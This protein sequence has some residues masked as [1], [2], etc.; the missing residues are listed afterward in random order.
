MLLRPMEL[1]D[2]GSL[3]SLQRAT[4]KD[5]R[6]SYPTYLDL[7]DRNHS[8]DGLATHL[9]V[10]AALDT[11]D[12]SSR[13]WV[14]SASGNY[15]DVLR[16]KPHLGRF[17]HAEDEHGPNSAPYVVLSY[18]YWRSHFNDD[19]RVIGR[20]VRIN[21]HPFTIIGVAPAEFH[22]TVLFFFPDLYTP[23]VNHAQV[24]DT[25]IL[26][27]RGMRFVFQVVG[28]LKAGVT[29]EQAAADLN[30]IGKWVEQNY[31]ADAGTLRYELGR[32]AFNGDF[33]ERPLKSF[34]GGLALLAGLI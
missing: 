2:I 9:G 28:H 20:V 30:S 16:I 5:G 27:V 14:Q 8:F 25:D 23:I 18:A 31:P 22:G 29:R 3:Y 13:V 4:D 15:F 17:F 11:G 33:F 6:E 19:P 12:N 10:P 1:P 24:S 7:R 32:P 26:S 21:Q 34:V